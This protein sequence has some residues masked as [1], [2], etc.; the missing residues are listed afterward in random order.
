MYASLIMVSLFGTDLTD[1]A[2]SVW[3]LDQPEGSVSS[4]AIIWFFEAAPAVFL[5]PFIGSFVD[6]WNK[7]KMIIYGQLVAAI[8]SILL[9]LLYNIGELQPWHI[10]VVSGIGSVAS[11]FV[12]T[13]FFVATTALVSKDKLIKAQGMTATLFAIIGMGV[14]ILAPVLYKMIGMSNI[15]LIDVVTFSIAILAFLM[16]NFVVV[17]QSDEEFSMKNDWK[18]IK[19]FLKKRKALVHLFIFFFGI[20]FFMGL[21]EVLFTP[22]ILDFSDEYVLG[23]VLTC[24]GLGTLVGGIIM[25]S[26]SS[27]KK[28]IQKITYVNI[29]VGVILALL[30][31]NVDIYVLAI[32]GMLVIMVATISD[33]INEAFSQTIIPVKMMG[34]LAGFEELVVG[35]AGPLAF[36]LSGF[37]VDTLKHFLKDLPPE[38]LGHFPGTITTPAIIGVFTIA[39]ISLIIFSILYSRSKPV[40]E[41]DKLYSFELEK[42]AQKKEAEKKELEKIAET[43]KNEDV[44]V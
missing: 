28:P 32:G 7:K 20:N 14:P 17:E 26:T 15:F 9:M 37:L 43:E 34:R 13:A 2:L 11:T 27:F 44:L 12:F 22:L 29:F 1:F 35:G 23:I 18:T 5:A 33:I 10:M 25:G 38:V 40:S 36:L 41:L 21:V 30:W 16:I 8:G 39:G 24:I 4:Y 31:I 3:V 19:N 42:E 6:R